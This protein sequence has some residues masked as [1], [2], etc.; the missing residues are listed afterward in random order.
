MVFVIITKTHSLVL[1]L[2]KR[3]MGSVMEKEVNNV[4]WDKDKEKEKE[5]DKDKEEE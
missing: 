5:K 2:K 1:T 3:V 4:E